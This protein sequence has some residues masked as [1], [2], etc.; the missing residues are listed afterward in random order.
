M[1]G[2]YSLTAWDNPI[3]VD[4]NPTPLLGINSNRKGLVIQN[5]QG[6]VYVKF[7][8]GCTPY[9]YSYRLYQSAVLEQDYQ[10]PI[11]ACV[12]SGTGICMVTEIV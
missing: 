7:G 9:N 10:G 5:T 2:V 1:A 12:Q 11:T 6:I 8:L 3:V 4:E